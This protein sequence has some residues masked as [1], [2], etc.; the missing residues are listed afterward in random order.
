MDVLEYY[1]GLIELEELVR[2]VPKGTKLIS[3]L[4]TN[5][6]RRQNLLTAFKKEKSN[7]LSRKWKKQ[8][9]VPTTAQLINDAKQRGGIEPSELKLI[10][11]ILANLSENERK[12]LSIDLTLKG[13]RGWSKIKS[14]AQGRIL[15]R[16]SRQR[17]VSI[18]MEE[19]EKDEKEIDLETGRAEREEKEGPDLISSG[20]SIVKNLIQGIGQDVVINAIANQLGPR[21]IPLQGGESRSKFMLRVLPQLVNAIRQASSAG[22][23]PQATVVGAGSVLGQVLWNNIKKL[24][25]EAKGNKPS[26]TKIDKIIKTEPTTPKGSAQ[27][28]ESTPTTPTPP[29]APTPPTP[30]TAPEP[31]EPKGSAQP[32]A[33]EPE[34][35]TDRRIPTDRKEAM[36]EIERLKNQLRNLISNQKIQAETTPEVTRADI[37]YKTYD[38]ELLFKPEFKLLDPKFYDKYASNKHTE[39]EDDLETKFR[40]VNEIT[41]GDRKNPLQ[42][43]ESKYN[44]KRY[45]KTLRRPRGYEP[46]GTNFLLSWPDQP[47]PQE[48]KYKQK[49]NTPFR[50][51]FEYPVNSSADLHPAF[52]TQVP[53]KENLVSLPVESLTD[54]RRAV[55]NLQEKLFNDPSYIS[56]FRK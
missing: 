34:P 41:S 29:T 19:D 3:F 53:F 1:K 9:Q 6:I 54:D 33:P 32:P 13:S 24:Y 48:M 8:I 18:P 25:P 47:K 46:V 14:E 20:M 50:N 22:L 56:K 23:I 40:Y 10:K 51:Q 35:S 31:P 16:P 28:P 39:L 11:P 17:E 21:L 37:G 55:F 12:Q 2:R 42:T 27:P 7:I 44:S 30:P 43:S 38:D 26:K 4:T 36:Q 45:S 5:K 49:M 52:Y 15:Q